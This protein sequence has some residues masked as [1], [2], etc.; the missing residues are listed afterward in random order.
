MDPYLD[1]AWK[2]I[3]NRSIPLQKVSH[4]QWDSR[5]VSQ[6]DIFFALSGSLT[7]G[8]YYLEE[9]AKKGA[10]GAVVDQQYRG[11]S[12]GLQLYP[13]DNVLV[14]LH[15][16]A[17]EL[18]ARRKP[19]IVGI[20][21][22]MGK[23]TTKE[24]LAY[25]LEGKVPFY[26]SPASYNSQIT[27]PCNILNASEE[28]VYILEMG[29][30]LVGEMEKLVSIAPPTVVV[31]TPLAR[32]HAS[33]LGN[34]QDIG[35]EKSKIFTSKCSFSVVY[36]K[37]PR[38]MVM[39]ETINKV[40]YGGERSDIFFHRQSGREKEILYKNNSLRVNLEAVPN[41]LQENFLAAMAVAEY[42][43]VDSDTIQKRAE[44]LPVIPMRFERTSKEG[45]DFIDDTY[46]A[47][48]V[49]MAAALRNFPVSSGKKIA[50]LGDMKELGKYS[51]KAH[52]KIGVLATKYVDILFC[53]GEESRHVYE[54]F[55]KKEKAHFLSK[56]LLVEDLRK[57][58]R[59]GDVV[60]VKGSRSLKMEEIIRTI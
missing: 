21:G 2:K 7:D 16:L 54:S 12:F 19:L 28:R 24:Y 45:I 46:N 5:K 39:P 15:L 14:T 23:T 13:V 53:L 48:P 37:N 42:L 51:K 59:S 52:E 49:S 36:Y 20:T 30:S 25:L 56:H 22:S 4:F 18:I 9:V 47:N 8:H 41:H 17:K 34:L 55:G 31:M 6:N 50:V 27:L 43:G 26:K 44:S 40:M 10:L 60:L 38:Y 29:V 32:A 58:I 57:V 3:C 33:Q 1:K 11:K 35:T